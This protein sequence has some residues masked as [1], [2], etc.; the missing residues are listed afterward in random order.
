MI[1]IITPTYN[2]AHLL[3]RLYLSLCKQ[4]STEFEWIIIDDGS[5]DDTKNIISIF[6][7]SGNLDIS[8][9]YKENGGKHT[10]LNLGVELAKYPYVFIVDS[11]DLLPNDSISIIIDKIN[12]ISKRADFY[13]LS[14]V[15]GLKSFLD[16][17][18]VGNVQYSDM[19]CNYLDFRYKLRISGDKAEI[20]KTDILRRFKF[21]EFEGEKF[22]PEALIWNR[23]SAK[24]N[25]FFFYENI[26]FCEYQ[27]G[28]LTENIYKIRKQSPKATLLYYKELFLNKNV[29][30][31]YRFRGLLNYV[32][33]FI[34]T[35]I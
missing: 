25:M 33:F 3:G 6:E 11:D 21:P 20:F 2:R 31:I 19:V 29:P 18:D 9:C 14:G 22:C 28:G 16:G 7:E 32:R 15:C 35:K 23:I 17:T 5:T 30:V 26:Y 4:T 24:Y 27:E 8:V 34:L 13:K 10:A 12:L 1:S